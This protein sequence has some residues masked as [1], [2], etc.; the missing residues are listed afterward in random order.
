MQQLKKINLWI[1]PLKKKSCGVEA[2]CDFFNSTIDLGVP[3]GGRIKKRLD[4][5]ILAHLWLQ[6]ADG[7]KCNNVVAI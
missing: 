5:E 6:C 2:Q 3:K 4:C 1:I 7:C